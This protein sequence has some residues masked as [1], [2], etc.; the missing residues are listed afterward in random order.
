MLILDSKDDD[1]YRFGREL[2]ADFASTSGY[3]DLRVLVNYAHGDETLE[4]MY[5]ADKLPRLQELKGR[6]DPT[7]AF[8]FQNPLVRTDY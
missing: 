5:G 3:P 6:W 7:N 1:A 2:R 8:G 4:Q